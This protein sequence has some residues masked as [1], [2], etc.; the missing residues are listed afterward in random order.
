MNRNYSGNI[1]LNFVMCENCELMNLSNLMN[2]IRTYHCL[3]EWEISVHSN[4]TADTQLSEPFFLS[5]SVTT[6]V[7]IRKQWQ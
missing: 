2:M 4:H 6:N 1:R 5:V 3:D 7:P